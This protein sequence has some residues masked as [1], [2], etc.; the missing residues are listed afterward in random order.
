MID[1]DFLSNRLDVVSIKRACIELENYCLLTHLT[2]GK[3][4]LSKLSV[5]G[6]DCYEREIF[7]K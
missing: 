2:G 7:P 3:K 4:S 6:F 5:A 1:K